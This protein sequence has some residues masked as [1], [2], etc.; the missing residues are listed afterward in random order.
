MMGDLTPSRKSAAQRYE[1]LA[2]KIGGEGATD[3]LRV[4][5]ELADIVRADETR[6]RQAVKHSLRQRRTLDQIALALGVPGRVARHRYGGPA[7]L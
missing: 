1:Q 6:L 4:V 3:D 7:D 5:A 2:A